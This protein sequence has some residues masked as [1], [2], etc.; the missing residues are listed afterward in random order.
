M[1]EMTTVLVTGAGGFLGRRIV[2]AAR[3]KGLP[4]R[5]LVR[6]PADGAPWAGDDG[7]EEVTLDL[8]AP[9]A[10]AALPLDGVG[11]VI[12]AAALMQGDDAGHARGTLAPMRAVLDAMIA[13]RTPRLVLVSSFSVYG[14]GALP[15]GSALDETVPTEPDPHL[16]DAYC[17]AKLAQEAMAIEA[18]QHHGLCVRALRPGAIYGDLHLWTARLGLRKGPL[19]ILLGGGAAVPAVQV[20]SCAEALAL[21]AIAPPP[22]RSDVPILQGGGALDFINIVDDGAPDQARWLAAI[23]PRLGIKRTIR[24]PAKPLFL[25]AKILGLAE[26]VFP[27]LPRRLPALLREGALSTRIKPLRHPNHRARE[28]LGWT[29][30][31]DFDAQISAAK[32]KA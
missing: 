6:R 18:A 20:D 1:G 32:A 19:A 12:H 13:A 25:A 30:G 11:A 27:A 8:A 17:R 10:A 2:A 24:I 28:R 16:R 3:A 5:A 31:A 22:P 26:I 7:V 9:A 4:V 21:A 14:Y 23:A 29:P 15:A